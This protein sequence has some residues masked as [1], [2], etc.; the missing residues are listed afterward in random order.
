[1][2]EKIKPGALVAT[3]QTIGLTGYTNLDSNN[4]YEEAKPIMLSPAVPVLYL[5]QSKTGY[6]I[7][8]MGEQK[9]YVYDIL[10]DLVK[11]NG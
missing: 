2:S 11:F 5:G 4:E 7:L 3:N 10:R 8:L 1:M 6:S 9:F